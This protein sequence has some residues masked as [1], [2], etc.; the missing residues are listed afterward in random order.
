[1]HQS[2]LDLVCL[3]SLNPN[4][5]CVTN[6]WAWNNPFYGP[7]I[8]KAG[9]IASIEDIDSMVPKAREQVEGGCSILAFPE[10]TR[11]KDGRIARFH[12]GAFYMAAKLGL[13]VLPVYLYG[14]GRILKKGSRHLNRGRMYL[15]VGK[16]L[17]RAELD[18][19]GELRDQARIVRKMFTE[20]YESIR[21]RQ[22]QYA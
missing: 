3:L 17:T 22:D 1:M 9:Y 19:M 5:V 12:K 14:T 13:D 6:E 2:H 10:G 18:A 21:N 11:S 15:E 16:P 20:K 4:I 8:R 7:V